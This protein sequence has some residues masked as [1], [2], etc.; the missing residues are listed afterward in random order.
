LP[1][2]RY[3]NDNANPGLGLVKALASRENTIVFAGTRTPATAPELNALA[4]QFKN[5]HVLKLTSSDIQD[6]TAAIDEIKR[7]A[8][9]LHVVIANAGECEILVPSRDC[10]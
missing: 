9:A 4:G 1:E 3:A 5:L 10:K 7:I 2:S 6:N 8:G